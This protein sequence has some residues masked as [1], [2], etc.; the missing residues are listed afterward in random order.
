VESDLKSERLLF[1][2]TL[3]SP[4][5]LDISTPLFWFNLSSARAL[6]AFLGHAGS[7]QTKGLSIHHAPR[8]K[9]PYWIVAAPVNH[10]ESRM[11]NARNKG[12]RAAIVV[13]TRVGRFTTDW[14]AQFSNYN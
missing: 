6:G 10:K 4:A 9:W 8:G 1:V 7:S 11:S 13:E 12:S 14:L 3:G 2:F 5:Y